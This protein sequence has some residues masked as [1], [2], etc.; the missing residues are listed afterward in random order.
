[1]SIQY[2]IPLLMVI[3]CNLGYHILSKSLPNNIN[4]F[5]GLSATYGV[6]FLGSLILF[7]ITKKTIY[8]NQKMN[9]NIYNLLLGIVIIGVEGGYMLMYRAGWEV[10]KASLVA[11]I[12]LSIL[13]LFIGSIV[14]HE[15][16]DIKKIA[17]IVLCV[18]GIALIK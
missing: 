13:L 5:I 11:N 16:V 2:Y 10:S 7:A 8:S 15:F 17:G 3:G 1:M 12:V 6:A 4:P 9:I 18:L 14:F